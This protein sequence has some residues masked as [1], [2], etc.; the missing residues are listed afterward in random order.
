MTLTLTTGTWTIAVRAT[1]AAGNWSKWRSDTVWVDSGVPTMTGLRLSQK[2]VRTTDGRFTATWAGT[3]NIGVTRYQWRT[4]KSP[5]GTPSTPVSTTA[6]SGSFRLAAGT[7]YID[8][9]ARDAVGNASP[10]LSARVLVPRDDRAFSFSAGTIRRTGSGFYRGTLT[11]TN[12]KNAE[13]V[14]ASA[15]GDLFAL[16]GRVGPTYGKMEITVDGTATVI[17][18]A[19]LGGKRVTTFHDRV[20]VFSARLTPGPHQVTIR[21]LG[22]TGRPTIA[23][24]GL[25]FAR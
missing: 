25:G 12:V 23:I 15:D 4:R 21:N 1:D 24:D 2:I 17:D 3:D 22:T 11:T 20:L 10:W 16:V 19:F 9:R 5:D 8:V 7:W 6:R 13:L 18:T 14:T